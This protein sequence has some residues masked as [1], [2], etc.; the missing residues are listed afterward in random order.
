MFSNSRIQ[1]L[2]EQ[3]IC[4]KA[5]PRD[6]NVDQAAFEYKSTRYV[7]EVVFLSPDGEVVA[8]LE[9]RTVRGAA[10]AMEGVL[11]RVQQS[12]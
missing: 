5:D 8:R 6:R 4:V 11:K 12:R 3:F 7:P 1:E 10:A 2:A 9:D